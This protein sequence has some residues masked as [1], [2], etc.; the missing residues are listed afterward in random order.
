[1]L[2]T[3]SVCGQSP[4]IKPE[5]KAAAENPR[6]DAIEK[7]ITAMKADNAAVREQLRKMEEQQK[8]LLDLVDRLQR[9]LDEG[10]ATVASTADQPIVAPAIA[11]AS[12][13]APNTALN[14][15]QAATD[16]TNTSVKPVPVAAQTNDDRYRDGMVIWQ[17]PDD[18]KVPFLLKFNIN[19]QLRYLNTLSSDETFTD[20]LGVVREVHT[21]QRYHGK[22]RD[23]HF[24]RLHLRQEAAI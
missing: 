4:L 18:A 13:P 9:R 22:S 1:M 11:D 14:P 16:S 17:T 19:T 15:P 3:I 21:T 6:P 12:A 2:F 23:V 5:K 10:A 8:V 24:R 20:H 7:E